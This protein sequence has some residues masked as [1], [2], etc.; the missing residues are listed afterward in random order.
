MQDTLT[1]LAQHHRDSKKF[2]QKIKETAEKRFGLEFWKAWDIHIVPVLSEKPKIADFGCGPGML[3]EYLRA[4]YSQAELIGVEYAPYMLEELDSS[5][6]QVIEHDLNKANLP[7]ADNSLDA[8]TSIFC[9]HEMIQPIRL[10]QSIHRCLKPGGRCFIIDWERESLESYV[11]EQT[12]DDLFDKKINDETLGELF[13]HF[14]EHN[15]YTFS[16]LLWL[17]EQTGF[18]VLENRRF[19]KD[20][21]RRWCIMAS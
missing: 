12:T 13:T 14:M 10:L 17:F 18:T 5:R 20:R 15:R 21:F 8:I 19:Q 1:Q 2:V 4:R 11:A 16:D 9:I 3:L 6:Y 7:I